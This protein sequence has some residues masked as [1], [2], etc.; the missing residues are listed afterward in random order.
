MSQ[1]QSILAFHEIQFGGD[2]YGISG[3]TPTDG[4]HAIK[5]GLWKYI[6]KFFIS[7]LTPKARAELDLLLQRVIRPQRQSESRYHLRWNFSFGVTSLSRLTADEWG[8]VILT[9][10]ILCAL[11]E[12]RSIF[13]NGQSTKNEHIDVSDFVLTMEQIL[14]FQAWVTFGPFWTNGDNEAEQSARDA[15]AIMMKNILQNV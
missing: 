10:I 11:P 3:L 1:H 12:G 8:G 4:L 7:R 9:L 6:A 13:Q 15:I 14:C 5:L 2:L